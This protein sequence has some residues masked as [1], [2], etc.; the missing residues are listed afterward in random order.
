MTKHTQMSNVVSHQRHLVMRRV[1]LCFVL[2]NFLIPHHQNLLQYVVAVF[3]SRL[4][5]AHVL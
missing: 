2:A 4:F 3:N 5:Y 1:V